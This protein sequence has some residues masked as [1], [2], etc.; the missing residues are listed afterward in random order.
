M[1]DELEHCCCDC[2]HNTRKK[3]DEHGIECSC[4]LD[5]HH[6]G[7]VACFTDCCEHW[8]ESVEDAE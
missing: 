6:I 4:E 2:E 3:I 7:Y 5:G 8:K 1:K